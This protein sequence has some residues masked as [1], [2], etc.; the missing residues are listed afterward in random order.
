MNAAAEQ[1]GW[2]AS[3]DLCFQAVERRTRLVHR[4]H[5]G[6][7]LVQRAFHPE[8]GETLSSQTAEPCHV[9]L[10]HPPAGVVG[11]DQV[12]L[13]VRVG[14]AAHALLTTPGA[15]KFYRRGSNGP[16]RAHQSLHVEDGV[17]EWLPQENIFYPDAA[18][19]VSTVVKLRGGA[20]F[21]GWEMACLGL[22]A[23]GLG[24]QS[25]E[26]RQCFELW[27]GDSPLLLDRLTLDAARARARTGSSGE[28]AIGTWLAFPAGHDEL[29]AAR[30]ISGEHTTAVAMACTLV[31]GVLVC[32]AHA[33]RSDRLK[34]A[35]V[36]LWGALRPGLLSRTASP[37]RIWAT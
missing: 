33:A 29:Q 18:A 32:R 27:R 10:I 13:A 34:H 16:A 7:L 9:Y 17:L 5:S 24:L 31:D 1:T 28:P 8:A 35:F 15:G 2:C 20:R 14:A 12:D 4:R 6:P 3:L 19:E 21:I 22:P 36:A 26:L 11:G 37:P 25:G 23:Q 30:T